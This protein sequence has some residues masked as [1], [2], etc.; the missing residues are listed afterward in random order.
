MREDVGKPSPELTR[1][2]SCKQ[3]G[4][5]ARSPR[6]QPE[7]G[8]LACRLLSA[9]GAPAAGRVEF[10]LATVSHGGAGAGR[11]P[12]A[13]I[14]VDV[15]LRTLGEPVLEVW[16]SS[17]EPEVRRAGALRLACTD[18]LAFGA[19]EVEENDLESD[20]GRAY[21]LLLGVLA[22][23][24]QRHLLRMWNV[25]PRVSEPARRP[26]QRADAIDRYMLFCRARSLAF[27]RHHGAA[28]ARQL[29]AASAVG[30]DGGPIVV[31]FLASRRPGLRISNPRQEEPWR[32]PAR[33]GPR[34]PSF[35]RA[36]R[37][38]APFDRTTLVSGTASIVGHASLHRDDL[39]GQVEETLRNLEVVAQTPADSQR[40]GGWTLKVFL[41]NAQDLEPVRARLLAAFGAGTPMLFL[42]AD[43]CRPEL[44]LEIEGVRCDR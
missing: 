35:A 41:R 22:D 13:G 16:T 21:D 30:S 6:L 43:M 7:T 39:L 19:I 38:P 14:R 5:P 1:E 20:V 2:M 10:V 37:A 40:A 8:A 33:Y 15:P 25:I 11:H 17:C 29:S 18:D 31:Y 4:V 44:A 28:F 12:P 34:P 26:A 27:E 36:M 32:Y 24:P 9:D 23:S 3:D 42:R